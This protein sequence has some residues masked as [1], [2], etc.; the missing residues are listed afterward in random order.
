MTDYP[1]ADAKYELRAKKVEYSDLNGRQTF[2]HRAILPI[3]ALLG[4]EGAQSAKAKNR[5]A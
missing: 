1:H 5:A 3:A 2:S 4:S